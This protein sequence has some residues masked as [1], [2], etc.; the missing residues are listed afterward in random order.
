MSFSSDAK[1]THLSDD[2][3]KVLVSRIE[4]PAN[5]QSV[6]GINGETSD[7]GKTKAAAFAK[8]AA[9]LHAET[10]KYEGMKARNMH[11]TVG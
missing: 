7:G 10:K 5:F 3:I 8:M 2:D 6:Y 9:P 1:I 11:L 4:I